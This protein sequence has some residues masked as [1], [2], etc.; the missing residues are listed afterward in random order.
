MS[1]PTSRLGSVGVTLSTGNTRSGLNAEGRTPA[2]TI[3][4][5]STTSHQA[6]APLSDFSTALCSHMTVAPSS[7]S[8]ICT[9]TV[10]AT[11]AHARPCCIHRSAAATPAVTRSS[12]CSSRANKAMIMRFARRRSSGAMRLVIFDVFAFQIGQN[13]A[14]PPVSPTFSTLKSSARPMFV[15]RVVRDR[16]FGAGLTRASTSSGDLG[17]QFVREKVAAPARVASAA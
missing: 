10:R 15:P 5:S 8:S 2:D 3:Y 4:S 16:H 7:P 12:T 13:R 14:L 11:T 9:S 6:S 1:D 17:A